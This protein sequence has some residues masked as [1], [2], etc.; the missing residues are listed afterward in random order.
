M[1]N[2]PQAINT[3]MKKLK[4]RIMS[5]LEQPN[6]RLKSIKFKNF[7]AFEDFAI[8]FQD[9]GFVQDFNCLV[10]PNGCG[11][12]TI[13][14]SIQLIFSRL[15]GMTSERIKMLLGKLVRHVDADEKQNG[16]YGDDDFLI[17][18]QIQYSLGTYEVQIN[19]TGFIKDHPQE[20]KDI[21]YKLCFYARFDQE[22][23]TFQLDRR[24]WPIFKELFEAVTG[25]KI[26]EAKILFDLS[27]DPIQAE[28]L[29]QYVLNF[30][31]Y[32][33]D[34]VI[35]RTECSSGEKKI[36]KSF[37]TLLNKVSNPQ[38]ILIDNVAMHVESGRHLELV[39]SMKKCFPKSQ[40]F[41]TTHS[42]HISRNF[43]DRSQLYDLRFIKASPLVKQE[44]WRLYLVDELEDCIAKLR[45]VD[46]K[47]LDV[48]PFIVEGKEII[49]RCLCDAR[50][51]DDLLRSAS[52]F[53][54][55]VVCYFI[56]DL[57]NYYYKG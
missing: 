49:N 48:E 37:S 12:S 22:L 14:D 34:E 20:V 21:I 47:D 53:M 50:G 23:S 3:G 17:T 55:K 16:I 27:G 29:K 7:K 28:I 1:Q 19:K 42:Y 36:I 11:K 51:N 15:D 10:G 9:K 45:A 38:I 26:K 6:I 33:P 25:F 30:D 44:Q 43:G 56:K 4:D 41:T 35:A 39:K 40:L 5:K 24:K 46:V 57:V 13:L 2:L 52:N 54:K 8:D 32:K 31:I 18:A